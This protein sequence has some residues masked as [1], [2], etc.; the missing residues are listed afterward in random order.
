MDKSNEPAKDARSIVLNDE[1]GPV[2]IITSGDLKEAVPMEDAIGLMELAFG[3][4]SDRQ[5]YVPPRYV[6]EIPGTDLTLILKP[7][8]MEKSGRA[9]VARV[10]NSATAS[11]LSTAPV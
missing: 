1:S 8:Y 9:A 4:Y 2:R 5:C 11:L 3:S 10:T 7:A 6:N